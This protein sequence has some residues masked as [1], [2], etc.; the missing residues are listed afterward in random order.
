MQKSK[1]LPGHAQ[2]SRPSRCR[3]GD[4]V[5][6]TTEPSRNQG[7]AGWPGEGRMRASGWISRVSVLKICRKYKMLNVL[8]GDGGYL[9]QYLLY[10]SIFCFTGKKKTVSASWPSRGG[11]F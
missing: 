6:W 10:F 8:F 11:P 3:N 5:A 1:P 2:A 4:K 9:L 7:G